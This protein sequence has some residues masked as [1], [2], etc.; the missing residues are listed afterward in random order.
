VIIDGGG[1]LG[2]DGWID[3]K[4]VQAVPW[5][6]KF[7]TMIGVRLTLYERGQSRVNLIEK[8]PRYA[9]QKD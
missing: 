9:G 1:T 4:F 8:E 7:A 3:I 5:P 2:P 6:T